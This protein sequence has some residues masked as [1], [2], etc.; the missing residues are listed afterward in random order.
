MDY[1]NVL[2]KMRLQIKNKMKSLNDEFKP[3]SWY[4]DNWMYKKASIKAA[5]K[6]EFNP[7]PPVVP[8]RTVW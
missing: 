2:L 3:C 1:T 5:A 6:G 7:L 4:R 8:R